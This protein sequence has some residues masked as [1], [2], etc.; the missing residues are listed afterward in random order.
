MTYFSFVKKAVIMYPR[1]LENIL[2]EKCN[3]GKAIIVMGAGQVG[4][5]TLIR[6]LLKGKQYLFLDADDP[7]L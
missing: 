5:T 6:K 4:K 3:T 7:C 1:T 2:R